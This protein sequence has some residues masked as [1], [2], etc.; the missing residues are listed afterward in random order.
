LYQKEITADLKKF[1]DFYTKGVENGWE[2]TPKVRMSVIRY[3]QVSLPPESRS[4]RLI[5]HTPATD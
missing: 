4:T 1:L 3:N 5:G 2:E